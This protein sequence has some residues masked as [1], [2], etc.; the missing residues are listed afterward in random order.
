MPSS[1]QRTTTETRLSSQSC[2]ATVIRGRC[3][4]CIVDERLLSIPPNPRPTSNPPPR[5]F[6]HLLHDVRCLSRG[7]RKTGQLPQWCLFVR[8]L[9]C[10]LCRHGGR[11]RAAC[12]PVLARVVCSSQNK[13]LLKRRY[14]HS[15]TFYVVLGFPTPRVPV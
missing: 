3:G 2:S 13:T 14:V 8:V 15:F 10:I 5:P 11:H 6:R 12:L 1:L 7:E 4:E 9:L